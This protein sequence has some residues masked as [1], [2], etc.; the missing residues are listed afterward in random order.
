VLHRP[1]RTQPRSGPAVQRVTNLVERQGLG[2]CA[3]YVALLMMFW[4]LGRPAL[5]LDEAASTVATQRSWPNLWLLRQGTDAPLVPYYALL[6]AQK[7]IAVQIFPAT[8]SHLE[9]LVRWPSAAAI[10]VAVW[11]LVTWL[12]SA[13]S[14]TVA[15]S[16]AA[17]LLLTEGVSRYGQEARPYALVLMMAIITTAVWWRLMRTP[18]LPVVITYAACVAILVFLHALAAPLVL[19]HLVAALLIRR[20]DLPLRIV[21]NVGGATAGL[22]VTNRLTID[23]VVQGGG[24]S[25]FQIW[26]GQHLLDAFLSLFGG[27]H[28]GPG[29]LA[30]LVLAAVGLT[31]WNSAR[32]ADITRVAA[33]W[34]VIPLLVLVPAMALRPNLLL[35]RYVLFV[36]PG[37]AILAGLGIAAVTE[38]LTA[39]VANAYAVLAFSGTVAL[40]SVTLLAA[41]Q[42]PALAAIRTPFGHGESVRPV[43]AQIDQPA[44]RSLP[45]VVASTFGSIEFGAYAPA[46]ARRMVNLRPQTDLPDIWP[47]AIARPIVKQALIS[48]P[49]IMLLARS[50][51]C[52]AMPTYLKGYEVTST[53]FTPGGW[54]FYLLQRTAPPPS[55]HRSPPFSLIRPVLPC[56]S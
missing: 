24:A 7:A 53:T 5:W 39:R 18:S 31:R 49:T 1:P 34:A 52:G 35:A 50:G 9:L 43:L 25:R 30:V 4:G 14:P 54:T 33:T 28:T 38:A 32:Y 23:A 27:P 44:Y 6:K 41:V 17:V 46:Q 16:S 37:W 42:W 8:A 55:R 19:A 48:A 21:A 12:R 20:D 2:F 15:L 29:F 56:R 22:L 45:I 3:A 10:V 36:V 26:T 13:A 40:C 47:E 51:R 11:V